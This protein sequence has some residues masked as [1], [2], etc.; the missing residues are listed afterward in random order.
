MQLSLEKILILMLGV[1][2]SVL[3]EVLAQQADQQ[4]IMQD[5]QTL[6]QEQDWASAFGWNASNSACSWNSVSC[7][8]SQHVRAL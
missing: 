3:V 5:Q 2:V 6:L 1:S 7:D 8:E 4:A